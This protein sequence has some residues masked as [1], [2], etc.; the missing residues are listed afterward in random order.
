MLTVPTKFDSKDGRILEVRGYSQGDAAYDSYL[1][2]H[3]GGTQNHTLTLVLKV[4]LSQ[5]RPNSSEFQLDHDLRPFVIEKWPPGEF[6]AFKRVFTAD[7]A[8]WN[9]RFWLIPPAGYSG[10]DV[11]AGNR[12]MRPNIYCHLYVDAESNANNAHCTIRVVYL[13]KSFAKAMS[14]VTNTKP[15]GGTFRSN[16]GLLD[17][18][19]GIPFQVQVH[20]KFR[21]IPHEVGHLLGSKHIGHDTPGCAVAILMASVPNVPVPGILRGGVGSNACYIGT[22]AGSATNVMGGGGDFSEANAKPWVD[23]IAIH[24]QTRPQGWRVSM[25]KIAPKAV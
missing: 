12:T 14:K 10:L 13:Q 15:T 11:Q 24:T 16:S 21:T 20:A 6:E 5:A 19:D 9:N 25:H 8:R 7:A 23:R 17:S 4:C 18:M 1:K 22:S 3:E 2:R